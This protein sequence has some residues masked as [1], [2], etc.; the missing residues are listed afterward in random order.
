MILEI[1]PISVLSFIEMRVTIMPLLPFVCKLS[2][3]DMLLICVACMW[4]C[5]EILSVSEVV[6]P[7]EKLLER[8]EEG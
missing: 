8:F 2:V 7:L 3:I 5:L 4:G 6:E 1:L